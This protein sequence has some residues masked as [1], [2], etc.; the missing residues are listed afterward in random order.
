MIL[1]TLIIGAALFV[2]FILTS[3]TKWFSQHKW[4]NGLLV[5]LSLILFLGSETLTIL[6]EHGNYGM[7]T[8]VSTQKIN[9]YSA[10]ASNP[11]QPAAIP[12]L[13]LRQNVGRD[14]LYIYNVNKQGKPK[15]KHTGIAD[16]N[17]FKVTRKTPYLQI[18]EE[19][20]VFKNGF[21]H[22]LFAFSGDE[23]VKVSTRNVFFVPEQHQVM[24][25]EEIQQMQKAMKQKQEMMK[26]AAKEQQRA[27]N[28]KK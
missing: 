25:T 4:I 19:K 11:K 16:Q 2:A 15:M 20:R 12:F 26:N 22:M 23:N 8:A 24:T 13:V 9:I 7:K 18:Q 28:S 27:T 1:V 3:G 17:Q 5:A 6:N 10:V 21:Y 14:P